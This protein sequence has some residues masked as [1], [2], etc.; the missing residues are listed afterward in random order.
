MPTIKT[1]IGSGLECTVYDVGNG[2]CYKEYRF[3]GDVES[4]YRSAK[5][6]FEAGIAPKVYERDEHGYY[7][8]IVETFGYLCDDCDDK[9]ACSDGICNFALD[10][11]GHR[12]LEKLAAIVCEV[13]GKGADFDLHI[14]NIGRKNGKLVAIDFGTESRLWC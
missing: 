12:K 1:E 4:A 9:Y 3:A 6:A 10:I 2:R 5:L 13:F 11:I 14:G 8:E 7:T